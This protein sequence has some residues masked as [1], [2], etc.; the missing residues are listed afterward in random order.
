MPFFKLPFYGFWLHSNLVYRA[1]NP[2]RSYTFRN[3]RTKGNTAVMNGY[4][5]INPKQLMSGCVSLRKSKIGFLNPKES[6]NGFCVSLL[7]RLIQDLSDHGASKKRNR[8]F[9][10]QSGFFGSFDAPWS[11]GE[12]SWIDLWN[13]EK[14]HKIRF[15]SLL[16]LIIQSRSWI[17][18]KK[19][20]L[21]EEQNV[22]N[23]KVRR[24]V[25]WDYSK[26]GNEFSLQVSFI[27]AS[28]WAE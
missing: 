9:H 27:I 17:F 6:E 28:F 10:F 16:D 18:L 8:R 25:R 20:A 12:I 2:F 4:R 22:K 5:K 21:R 3:V 26:Y 24:I 13:S 14:K 19:R 15:R 7:N 23:V 11:A 1:K